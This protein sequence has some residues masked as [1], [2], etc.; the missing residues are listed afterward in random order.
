MLKVDDVFAGIETIRQLADRGDFEA[1]HAE[2]DALREL[3][4]RAIADGASDAPLLALA[5]LET[6]SVS[7]DR[8]CA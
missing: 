5:A 6:D 3:V 8:W 2:E 4:L 7:F 1:A